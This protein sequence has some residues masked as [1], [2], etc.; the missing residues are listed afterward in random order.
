[1][2]RT[3]TAKRHKTKFMSINQ[4]QEIVFRRHIQTLRGEL[5]LKKRSGVF[6]TRLE[7]FG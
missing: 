5:K 4:M 1:M 7:E 2:T 3:Y 6:L